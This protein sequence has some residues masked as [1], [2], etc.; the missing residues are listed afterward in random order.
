MDMRWRQR[1]SN[2]EHQINGYLAKPFDTTDLATGIEWVLNTS[3]Y[4]ELSANARGKVLTEF[5]SKVVAKRY[6]ELY[7]S[8]L[9]KTKG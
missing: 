3:N 6:V 4:D 2:F 5:D 8:V 1:F 7:E 9:E